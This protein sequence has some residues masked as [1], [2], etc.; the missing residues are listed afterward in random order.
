MLL[1][2]FSKFFKFIKI[3]LYLIFLQ[4]EKQ[5]SLFDWT[6]PGTEVYDSLWLT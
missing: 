1:V 4:A 5:T 3:R 6:T 2:K